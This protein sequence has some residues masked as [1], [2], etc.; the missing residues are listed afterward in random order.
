MQE[1]QTESYHFCKIK[2]HQI[3]KSFPK[4]FFLQKIHENC[5]TFSWA[6][7]SLQS[8]IGTA[9]SFYDSNG[10]SLNFLIPYILYDSDR[11]ET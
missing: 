9:G 3:R 11:I 6:V 5:L 8:Q 2:Y 1:K 10:F 4:R 7:L